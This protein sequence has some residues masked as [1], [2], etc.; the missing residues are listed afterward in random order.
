LLLAVGLLAYSNIR[1]REE[2]QEATAQKDLDSFKLVWEP[3][4][5]TGSPTLMVLSN[6]SVFRFI[7][8]ADPDP[9]IKKSIPL[10]SEDA[11]ASLE[12][13]PNKSMLKIIPMPRLTLTSDTYTGIGEAI[14]VHR[15]TNVFRSFEKNISLRQ[16]R[17]VSVEDLKN[18]N[19]IVLGS[20]WVNN[21]SG[22]LPAREEFIYSD[23][24]TVKNLN[25]LPGEQ[26][27]YRAS[28]DKQSG[29]LTEDYAIIT[30]GPNISEKDIV[31]ILAGLH[32]E[33]TAAAAEYVTTK[34]YLD[35]L[36]QKL[37]TVSGEAGAPRYYQVLLKAGVDN[38]IPTTITL[39]SL[40]ELHNTL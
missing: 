19:V 40:R 4:I 38:G 13:L 30:V 39:V 29:K 1:L 7:N 31:M 25:P 24:V 9:I 36:N 33:G 27:E 17:T 8:Q 35:E 20:V 26:P 3:F 6:P 2:V 16:S 21:W 22:K 32:S 23:E 11:L 34:H 5:K 28:F 18:Q 14:G 12:A 15:V 10:A 37:G